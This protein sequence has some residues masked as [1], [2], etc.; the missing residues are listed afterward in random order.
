MINSIQDG[1]WV[2]MITPFTPDNQIDYDG[3]AQ[4]VD[5]YVEQGIDGI[6]AVCQSSEMFYLDLAERVKLAQFVIQCANGRIPVVI[7][8]HVSEQMDEQLIE[9]SAMAA[10]KPAAVVLVSNRLAAVEE[11]DGIWKKNAERILNHIPDTTFG[12][13]ECP[14]PYK[15]LMSPDLLKWCADTGRFRFLKDTCC[16]LA[17][18][19]SKLAATYGTALKI[20]NANSATCLASLHM[21]CSGFCGVML[22]FH[23]ELYNWLCKNWRNG[24]QRAEQLQSF[25][26]IA[27]FIEL[28]MYPV[29][30]KYHLSLSGLDIGLETR[31]KPFDTFSELNRMETKALFDLWEDYRKTVFQLPDD[32][33]N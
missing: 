25:A 33:R 1:T 16:D 19:Q 31:S 4:L 20:F 7:S 8:G 17:Q 11:D 24:G 23:P 3:V 18:I 21:G 5:W 22:N 28:Q 32:R 10:L 9:L 27:S 6:F 26:T 2:T 29:N 13:Y 12:I 30:A 15:R 14:Y